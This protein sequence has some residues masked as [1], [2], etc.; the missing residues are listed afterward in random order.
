M[1]RPF[2]G[3]GRKKGGVTQESVC[4]LVNRESETSECQNSYIIQQAETSESEHRESS[5]KK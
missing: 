5:D 2:E 1:M 3:D 4:S